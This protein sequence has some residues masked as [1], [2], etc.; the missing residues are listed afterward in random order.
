MFMIRYVRTRLERRRQQRYNEIWNPDGSINPDKLLSLSKEYGNSVYKYMPLD[1]DS[2]WVPYNADLESIL[3]CIKGDEAILRGRRLKHLHPNPNVDHTFHASIMVRGS[4]QFDLD[5]KEVTEGL[6]SGPTQEIKI[7]VKVSPMLYNQIIR[8]N[9]FQINKCYQTE[10]RFHQLIV[11]I[12]REYQKSV[13]QAYKS[14]IYHYLDI[15]E[16][17][18]LC[19][20][21]RPEWP[22]LT[23]N[24]RMYLICMPDMTDD[25]FLFDPLV[26]CHAYDAFAAVDALARFHAV[27]LA[28]KIN[29]SR[30]FQQTLKP[31]AKPYVSPADVYFRFSEMEKD[32]AD[33]KRIK[34]LKKH[35]GLIERVLR[36]SHT[37]LSKSPQDGPWTGLCHGR[38]NAYNFLVQIHPSDIKLRARRCI[39][40]DMKHVEYNSVLSDVIFL[41]ITSCRPDV[42]RKGDLDFVIKNYSLKLQCYLRNH[43]LSDSQME[44]YS[45]ENCLAE[46]KRVFQDDILKGIQHLKYLCVKQKY[47][48]E[49]RAFSSFPTL[50]RYG[51]CKYVRVQKV[52][53]NERLTVIF[54]K[55]IKHKFIVDVPD[56]AGPS[57][58]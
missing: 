17:H 16:T 1:Q 19:Y 32:L 22:T 26:G 30:A 54:R 20:G 8:G 11:P 47:Q 55:L 6:Y 53:Y 56:E 15:K 51:M 21:T 48:Q 57:H 42:F 36:R 9:N 50:T 10:L 38:A 33:I 35:W 34:K 46:A 7:F 27:S 45:M 43:L 12:L 31:A 24:S 29:H 2:H 23:T 13:N 28:Y 49:Y 37:M 58:A 44:P 39:L 40:T 25:Y 52:T 18:P 5:H 4:I 14:P 3:A 41:L